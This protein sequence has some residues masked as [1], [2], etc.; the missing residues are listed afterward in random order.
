[1]SLKSRAGFDLILTLSLTVICVCILSAVLA[2]PSDYNLTEMRNGSQSHSTMLKPVQAGCIGDPYLNP[3]CF[4]ERIAFRAGHVCASVHMEA[5]GR[6][7]EGNAEQSF[8][9]SSVAT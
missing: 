7:N 6:E 4:N 1:M 9:C 8:G 5:V 2:Q 3:L